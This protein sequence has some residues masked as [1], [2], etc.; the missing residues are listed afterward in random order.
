MSEWGC[1]GQENFIIPEEGQDF[2]GLP[3]PPT[4]GLGG[5]LV[6]LLFLPLLLFCT[7]GKEREYAALGTTENRQPCPASPAILPSLCQP[8]HLYPRRSAGWGVLC[9]LCYLFRG[10]E[11][12][13]P[14]WVSQRKF[15]YW[16]LFTRET[17]NLQE[18]QWGNGAP[19][20]PLI[21][22]NFIFHLGLFPCY[23]NSG[24]SQ[25]KFWDEETP[26]TGFG[27]KISPHHVH[28]DL[29]REIF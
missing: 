14:S 25:S 7:V 29:L 22:W 5:N 28:K 20:H 3:L 4:E 15:S 23:L 13:S 18:W 8:P 6:N 11:I 17:A 10:K 24:F 19:A 1:H 21:E 12:G 27:T 16:A 2:S 26:G 9:R